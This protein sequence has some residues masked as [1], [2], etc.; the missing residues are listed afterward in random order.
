[1]QSDSR[2]PTRLQQLP[3]HSR[4]SFGSLLQRAQDLSAISNTLKEWC[5]EPWISQVRLA[6][7][8]G[9][10]VILYAA[11]AG[12]MVHLRH[13]RRSL[14]TWLNTRHHLCCT[15]VELQVRPQWRPFS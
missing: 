7:I 4:R 3:S 12:A 11:N 5:N 1:M 13:R 15:R 9:E 2:E 14:L 6:N 10:T 8:R